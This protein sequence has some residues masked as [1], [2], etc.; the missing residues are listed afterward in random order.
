[1]PTQKHADT[2][3]GSNQLKSSVLSRRQRSAIGPHYHTFRAGTPIKGTKLTPGKVL[4]RGSE[5]LTW[6]SSG[7]SDDK[8]LLRKLDG[9][10]VRGQGLRLQPI[11]F[12]CECCDV[13]WVT[14]FGD[15]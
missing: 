5:P 3:S 11:V 10:G 2:M 12:G 14:G 13:F 7:H 8:S 15:S 6:E 1:M 9:Y 4:R